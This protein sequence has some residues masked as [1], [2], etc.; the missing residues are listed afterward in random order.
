MNR[1]LIG[2]SNAL[3]PRS[4]RQMKTMKARRPPSVFPI[5][6]NRGSPLRVFLVGENHNRTRKHALDLFG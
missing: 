1:A 2:R 4:A 3:P 6:F 5:A